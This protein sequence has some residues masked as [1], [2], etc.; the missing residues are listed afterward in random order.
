MHTMQR[1]C[2]SV[3]AWSVSYRLCFRCSVTSLGHA[4]EGYG[5][6][7]KWC[8]TVRSR[9]IWVGF[10]MLC[11]CLDPVSISLFFLVWDHV[12]MYVWHSCHHGC[13]HSRSTSSFPTSDHKFSKSH[14]PNNSFLP[15]VASANHLVTVMRMTI[16]AQILWKT[17]GPEGSHQNILFILKWKFLV[18]YRPNKEYHMIGQILCEMMKKHQECF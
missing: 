3:C 7:R 6:F 13:S 5:T 2:Y 16:K 4:F 14:E 18:L 1:N 12:N 10:W 9:R 8:L 17:I 15:K 11:L